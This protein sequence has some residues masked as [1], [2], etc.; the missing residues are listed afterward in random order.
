MVQR[1]EQK[2]E[3]A[4]AIIG[5]KGTGKNALSSIM[6]AIFGR[7]HSIEV[8]N[9]RHIIGNFNE[10]LRFLNLVVLNEA[11]W[12]GDREAE[13][14]LKAA[15]T[16]GEMMME[17]K[18]GDST[19]RRN[20]WNLIIL[21]N[22]KF[23]M[24]ITEDDRRF[25]VLRISNEMRGNHQYFARLYSAIEG[26]VEVR[27]FMDFLLRRPLPA[28][29]RAASYL[30]RTK[31]MIDVMLENLDQVCLAWLVEKARE[32]SWMVPRLNWPEQRDA[33]I[34][35][36]QNCTCPKDLALAAFRQEIERHPSYH[37]R[38]AH[39]IGTVTAFTQ[40][41]LGYL[42][43]AVLF[44]ANHRHTASDSPCYRFGPM[45]EIRRHLAEVV[46]KV[47]DYFDV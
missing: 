34:A 31:A 39:R 10:H 45:Q 2:L 35:R 6:R 9:P 30:P 40:M 15:I 14:V 4:L 22:S 19:L 11:V 29:W 13:S 42:P 18:Y 12:G 37:I 36:D 3:V 8:V 41:L 1:P 23:P 38:R 7:R 32:G 5:E 33:Y 20:Y 28:Q 25:F 43:D 47:P 17:K 24:P 27:E 46:L 16:D 21:S 44:S 26:G